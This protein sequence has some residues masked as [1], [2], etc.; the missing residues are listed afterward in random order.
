MAASPQFKVYRGK[1]YIAACKYAEDAAVMVAHVGSEGVVKH[2][3]SLVVWR[4]GD[5]ILSY[6]RAARAMRRRVDMAH[7]HARGRWT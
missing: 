7:E 6:D 4:N 5:E 3:H 1:E 2:G